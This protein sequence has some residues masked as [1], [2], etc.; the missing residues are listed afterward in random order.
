MDFNQNWKLSSLKVF[1]KI[2]NQ[3]LSTFTYL[4]PIFNPFP[5]FAP[6]IGAISS[7]LSLLS[8]GFQPNS[9]LKLP[10]GIQDD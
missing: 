2:G 8:I 10:E 6:W 7:Q 5:N 1:N 4:N 3:K 9:E